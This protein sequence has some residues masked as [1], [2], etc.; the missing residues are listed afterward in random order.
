MQAFQMLSVDL[1]PSIS[2]IQVL[3]LAC[4]YSSQSPLGPSQWQLAGFAMRVGRHA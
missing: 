4:I 3:L 2:V 1:R